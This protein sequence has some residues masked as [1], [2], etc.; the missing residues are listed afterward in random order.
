[1]SPGDPGLIQ[2][3]GSEAISNPHSLLDK[4]LRSA[5]W[6]NTTTP[7]AAMPSWGG[8][9]NPGLRSQLEH[10]DPDR[11]AAQDGAGRG[12]EAVVADRHRHVERDARRSSRRPL[13]FALT[14][15]A[16]I[17]ITRPARPE[18]TAAKRVTRRTVRSSAPDRRKRWNAVPGERGGEHEEHRVGARRLGREK[19]RHPE[20]SEPEGKRLDEERRKGGVGACEFGMEDRSRGAEERRDRGVNEQSR[21]RRR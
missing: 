1:M 13:S 14:L 18:T 3:P 21:R 12:P 11:G 15:C 9:M 16:M 7:E 6:R 17:A 8:G 5:E 4:A 10:D 19:R 20:G 2:Q